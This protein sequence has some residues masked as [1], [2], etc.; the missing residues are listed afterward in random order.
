MENEQLENQHES[1][2]RTHH[3]IPSSIITDNL[4]IVSDINPLPNIPSVLTL[5]LNTTK[6]SAVELAIDYF[7]MT[8]NNDQVKDKYKT[9]INKV[10]K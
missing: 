6:V 9:R 10:E 4:T 1:P 7:H 2:L 8:Q 5:D 3:P